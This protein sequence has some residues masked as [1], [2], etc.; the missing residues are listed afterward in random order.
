MDRRVWL[1]RLAKSLLGCIALSLFLTAC[2]K[3][4]GAASDAG[5]EETAEAA[6]DATAASEPS[7]SNGTDVARFGDE[8]KLNNEA[9][10]LPVSV[11]ART[12]L[13]NGG[14]VVALIAKGTAVTKLA[15][16]SG[17][18]LVT[19]ANPKNAS[20][21]LMGWI[22]SSALKGVA[23]VA[24]PRDAGATDAGSAAVDAGPAVVNCP[25]NQVAMPSTTGNNR[26]ATKCTKIGRGSKECR[27]NQ[28][29]ITQQTLS[30]L[31]N[32]CVPF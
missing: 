2:P 9:A 16:H 14:T 29:C 25:A 10:N 26:C 12:D 22:P 20:D 31:I 15:E 8:S 13:G 23:A 32:V 3:K 18:T 1:G 6:T 11:T 19:F 17:S 4:K 21:T 5:D 30:G 24:T 27:A 28:N 7:A